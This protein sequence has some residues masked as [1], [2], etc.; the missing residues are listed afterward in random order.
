MRCCAQTTLCLLPRKTWGHEK[1]LLAGYVFTYAGSKREKTV[2]LPKVSINIFDVFNGDGGGGGLERNL[3]LTF[4][5]GK[6]RYARL[7]LI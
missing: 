1:S 2:S 5:V 6:N 4:L 3:Q 7:P